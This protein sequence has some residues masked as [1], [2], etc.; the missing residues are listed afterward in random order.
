ME[1]RMEAARN[2]DEP[3]AHTAS[4]SSPNRGGD[5]AKATRDFEA[6]ILKMLLAQMRKSVDNDPLFHDRSM[7]G[8]RALLDDALAKRAAAA[9]T[10]GLAQQMQK[11]LEGR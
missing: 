8:Y 3:L 11:N 5:L 6:Y 4:A 9:G 10:F 2:L 1:I 7:D